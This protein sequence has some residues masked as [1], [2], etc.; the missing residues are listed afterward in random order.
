MN[1]R[2]LALAAAL[3]LALTGAV[4]A[5]SGKSGAL[6]AAGRT[7]AGPGVA[8]AISGAGAAT[9]LSGN[10]DFDAC[11]TAVNVGSSSA[12]LTLSGTGSA[13]IDL[14]PGETQVLCRDDM[15]GMSLTCLGVGTDSCSV[16]WRV[17]AA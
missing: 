10:N 11:V 13:S 7:I 6:L 8:N 12:S 9:I 15:T 1:P 2:N 17:D 14:D 16:E 5:K 3:V 4:A